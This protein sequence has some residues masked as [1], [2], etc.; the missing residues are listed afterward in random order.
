MRAHRAREFMWLIIGL[1]IGKYPENILR[2]P[3]LEGGPCNYTGATGGDFR[4]IKLINLTLWSSFASSRFAGRWG[5]SLPGDAHS[6]ALQPDVTA[7]GRAEV[8]E[9]NINIGNMMYGGAWTAV[10]C[11]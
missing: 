3:Y 9:R 11:A 4:G 6:P 7:G 8:S 5:R 2:P 10:L 1:H